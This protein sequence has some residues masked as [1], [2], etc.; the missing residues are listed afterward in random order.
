MMKQLST[1]TSTDRMT[2]HYEKQRFDKL[3]E[4]LWDKRIY[5][6]GEAN[7]HPQFSQEYNMHTVMSAEYE[8]DQETLKHIIEQ[9]D[10]GVEE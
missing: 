8:R 1:D 9:I 7:K 10:E 6:T 4:Y 5:H 2:R 3:D